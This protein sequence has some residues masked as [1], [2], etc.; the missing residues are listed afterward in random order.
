LHGTGHRPISKW[1]GYVLGVPPSFHGDDHEREVPRDWAAASTLDDH[2]DRKAR[3][4]RDNHD[5]EKRRFFDF[6]YRHNIESIIDQ[7]HCPLDRH[8]DHET[9]RDLNEARYHLD[10]HHHNNDA[11][12]SN[13]NNDA[14][15]SNHNNHDHREHR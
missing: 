2:D 5:Y 11:A 6:D 10:R 9:D 1:R 4:E 14:A 15:A 12:A 8:L 13:H 3:H 7:F